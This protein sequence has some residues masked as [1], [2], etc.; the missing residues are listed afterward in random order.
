MPVNSDDDEDDDDDEDLPR[1]ADR[2]VACE[3]DEVADQDVIDDALQPADDVREHRRPRDLPDGRTQRPFDDRAVELSALAGGRGRARGAAA[4]GVVV[5]GTADG[6]GVS[7]A[8][9]VTGFNLLLVTR[10]DR[11]SGHLPRTE[12]SNESV[13]W[14]DCTEYVSSTQGA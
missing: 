10:M 3:A 7:T 9:R 11:E 12:P 1:D 14:H 8:G 13:I 4:D 2:R 5:S 6:P